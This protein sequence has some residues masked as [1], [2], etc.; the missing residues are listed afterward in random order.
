MKF[1]AIASLTLLGLH[2]HALPSLAQSESGLG[3]GARKLAPGVM[4]VVRPSQT[5]QDTALGPFDLDFVSKH[6]ELEWTAPTF[7]ENQPFFASPAETLLAQSRAVTFRHPVWGV[8]FAFKPVRIIDVDIPNSSG[9]M[10]RKPV[11]Y[12]CY[13]VRYTGDDLLPDTSDPSDSEAVPGEPKRVRFD[14]VRFIPR[15]TLISKERNVVSDA[16]ILTTAVEAVA[17]KER[18]PGRLLDHV[19]IARNEIKVSTREDE[20]ALWGVATW[21]DVDPNIDFFAI[22]VKGLT[23]AYQINVDS[24]GEKRFYRKTLRIY[25]WRPGDSFNVPKD[26]VYLGAPAYEDPKRVQYYLNQFSLKE[27]LDYQWI[28]R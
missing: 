14:S 12:L 16:Q 7:P 25:F 27:R 22:E 1:W 11:W 4:T 21:T 13:R 17:A 8:E 20:N 6:P 2:V 9:K 26:K 10:E 3:L 19:E 24:G 23:N 18:V 5:S 15:F 28:Y